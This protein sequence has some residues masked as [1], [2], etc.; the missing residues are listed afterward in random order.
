MKTSSLNN[1]TGQS[2][3]LRTVCVDISKAS[4]TWASDDGKEGAQPQTNHAVREWLRAQLE[5]TR[6]QGFTGLQIVCESTSGYHKRL[7]QLLQAE[8]PGRWTLK[9]PWHPLFLDTLSDVYP[10]AQLVMTHRDPAD[11]V[12]SSCNLIKVVR[13]LTSETEPWSLT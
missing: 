13:Q 8:A 11:V 1:G 5:E 9:N 3:K 6:R 10:D 7:L 2:E 12:G 4:F